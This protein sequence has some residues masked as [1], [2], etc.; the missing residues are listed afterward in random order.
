MSSQVL[1]Q[2]LTRLF[3]FSFPRFVVFVQIF[4]SWLWLDRIMMFWFVLSLKYRRNLSEL[5]ISGL[6]CPPTEAAEL[7]FW[8]PGYG[9]LCWGTIPLLPADQVGV[10]LPWTLAIMFRIYSRRNNFYVYAFYRNPGHDGSLYDSLHDSM[11]RVQSVDDKAVFV[12]DANAHHSEWLESSLW[13][14]EWFSYWSTHGRD[15]LDSWNLSGCEQLVRSPTHI[16]GN[17]LDLVLKDVPDIV[18]AFVRTP[19]GTSDHCFICCVLR[20]EQSLSEYNI[21]PGPH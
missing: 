7:Y 18:D 10:Y 8:Y 1:V 14:S 3:W 16:A 13:V 15:A 5:R 11:A 9:S 20:V 12:G 2:V 19:L 4:M 21:V 17:R 6:G